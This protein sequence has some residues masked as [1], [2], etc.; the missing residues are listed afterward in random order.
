MRR[1][2]APVVSTGLATGS[3]AN[4]SILPWLNETAPSLASVTITVSASMASFLPASSIVDSPVSRSASRWLT[5]S[6]RARSSA[7]GG[8]PAYARPSSSPH[9]TK[10]SEP[11]G[12]M[13]SWSRLAATA[14]GEWASTSAAS[15]RAPG[16]TVTIA[17]SPPKG[18]TTVVGVRGAGRVPIHLT[19]SSASAPRTRSPATSSP[20]GAATAAERPS[21]VAP[22]AVIA[23][24]PGVRRSS[25]A[26]R[27]S[28]SPGS[29]SR[30]T[31]VRSRNTGVATTRSIKVVREYR[32]VD[33]P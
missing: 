19:P 30:P 16:S 23:P 27:S 2:P 5:K 28:P 31:N 22:T 4:A 15:A 13:N 17:R 8:R 7:A 10:P 3:H 12:T 29:D 20:S 24:P 25:A 6:A 21:R 33:S 14:R 1:S 26:K 9:V 32:G 18:R 11:S